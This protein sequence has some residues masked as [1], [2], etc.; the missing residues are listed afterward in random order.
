MAANPIGLVAAAVGLLVTGLVLLADNWDAVIDGFK[1][2]FGIFSAISDF[3]G[4]GDAEIKK[5]VNFEG[6]EAPNEAKIAA[7]QIQF[8]GNINIAGAPEGTTVDSETKGAPAI[9]M[10]LAGAGI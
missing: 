5:T 9:N 6:R 4:D 1:S 8:Q 2:G 7:Q 3:F 10:K